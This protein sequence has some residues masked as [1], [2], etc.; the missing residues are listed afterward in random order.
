MRCSRRRGSPSL[1]QGVLSGAADLVSFK[2]FIKELNRRLQGHY[3]Y[4]GLRGDSEFLYRF[5]KWAKQ[6]AFKWLN[7]RGRKRKSF[8]WAAFERALDHLG[9]ALPKITEAKRQHVVYA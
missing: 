5:Y 7:R 6:C 3:N 4:Y 8:T 9:I 2:Q 1:F